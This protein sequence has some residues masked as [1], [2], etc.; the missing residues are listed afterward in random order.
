M[1]PGAKRPPVVITE[2]LIEAMSRTF[3]VA[4]RFVVAI[5]S[6]IPVM[7]TTVPIKPIITRAVVAVRSPV[8]VRVNTESVKI[9][10]R[11]II[12]PVV[13]TRIACANARAIMYARTAAAH[14]QARGRKK[15]A[16]EKPLASRETGARKHHWHK[17]GQSHSFDTLLDSVGAEKS[18]PCRLFSSCSGR[19][20][21]AGIEHIW[22][23]QCVFDRDRSG[24]HTKKKGHYRRPEKPV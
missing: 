7:G 22:H 1:V 3:V 13:R 5:G 6:P 23:G 8:F 11:I 16:P 15:Q 2:R 14:Q 20:S 12:V 21:N 24:R 19:T 4:E 17:T 9:S 18:W 10:I